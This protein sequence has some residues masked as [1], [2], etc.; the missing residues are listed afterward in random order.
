MVLD[1]LRLSAH[2]ERRVVHGIAALRAPY[3]GVAGTKCTRIEQGLLLRCDE[4]DRQGFALVTCVNVLQ[5]L[6]AVWIA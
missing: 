6:P 3:T 1:G 4:W 5:A 2:V